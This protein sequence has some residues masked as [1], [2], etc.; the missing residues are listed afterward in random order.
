MNSCPSIVQFAQNQERT[1]RVGMIDSPTPSST[2]CDDVEQQERLF[3]GLKAPFLS[4]K[5]ISL[6][7]L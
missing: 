5:L 7:R 4:H 1:I 2:A 6:V 3:W